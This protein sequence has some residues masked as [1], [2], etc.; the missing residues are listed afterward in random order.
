VLWKKLGTRG[1]SAASGDLNGDGYNN[2][3]VVGAWNKIFAFDDKG[4]ILWNYSV[5]GYVNHIVVIDKYVVAGVGKSLFWLD[6]YGIARV[7]KTLPESIIA[8]APIDVDSTGVLDG[9]VVIFFD[10]DGKR[11]YARAYEHGM[12]KGLNFNRYYERE[13]EIAIFPV[14]RRSK[15]KFDNVVFNLDDGIFWVGSKGVAG[16]ITGIRRITFT[17]ADFDGD[18]ILDDILA[19]KDETDKSPGLTIAYDALGIKLAESNVSGAS[20]IVAI[21]FDFD[22][23]ANDAIGASSFDRRIYSV[24]AKVSDETTS[25]PETA[26]PTTP[27]PTQPAPTP[28]PSPA[29]LSVDLGPDKTITEG[30]YIIL[31]PTVVPSTPDGKIVSYVWTEEGK[32]LGDFPTLNLSL[33]KGIHNI[34]LKVTDSVGASSTDNV[35]ITVTSPVQVSPDTDSDGDGW[36]DEKEKILGTDPLK[37]DTDNDGMIDS[38]DPNPLVPSGIA[39]KGLRVHGI[40]KWI[41]IGLGIGLG[42]FIVI[43]IREKILDFMWERRK[44]W[45]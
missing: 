23:I 14:D 6:F 22:G 43:Y 17:L 36:T 28:A 21:D 1:Y 13:A 35:I 26:P 38:E 44:E 31:S 16:S 32:F 37:K 19:A 9:V 11:A 41:M 5:F 25:P 40:T 33:K 42:I 8:L 7:S 20:K 45:E 15:R 4:N 27:A 30:E 18:G 34:S 2:E 10:G 12:D 29:N 24:I 3:I 39:L